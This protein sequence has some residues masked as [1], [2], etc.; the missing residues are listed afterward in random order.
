[1]EPLLRDGFKE[2]YNMPRQ[3]LPRT[4]WQT[5]H[6]D[7]IRA[8]TI[9]M[10]GSMSGEIILPLILD[11]RYTVDIDS[12]RDLERGEWLLTSGELDVVRPGPDPRPLPERVDL[13]VV[14]FDGVLTDNRVWVDGEGREL[15]AA[16]RGDGWGIARAL[17]AEIPIAV[18]STETDPVVAARCAKLGVPAVQGVAEKGA[19]LR[20]L[21]RERGVDGGNVVYLGNDVN[22]LPCFRLVGCAVVPCDAHWSARREADLVLR[23]RGGRGAV[24]ELC[25]ILL[26]R[27]VKRGDHG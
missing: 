10:K 2:P 1:M 15:V 20:T 25:D 3:A 11:P 6:V 5:G 21:L 4:Y 22:D 26:E 8:A 19:A 12:P 17:E 27:K 24:R 9:R 7:A 13:L 18:L 16:D 23:S 14:D